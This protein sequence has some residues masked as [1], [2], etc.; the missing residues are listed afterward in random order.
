[1][2][3]TT[4]LLVALLLLGGT[5]VFAQT[6]DSTRLAARSSPSGGV[7]LTLEQALES[8]LN[9][10]PAL[11]AKRTEI[12]LQRAVKRTASDIGK[13]NVSLTLGQINSFVQDNNLSISQTIPFPTVL[14][15]QSALGDEQI[16]GAELLAAATRNDLIFAVKS[17]FYQIAV[18]QERERLLR[19]QDSIVSAFAKAAQNRYTAGETTQLE[20][21]IAALQSS[22]IAAS[23]AQTRADIRIARE[24]LQTLTASPVPVNIVPP[25]ALKRIF[26]MP[27]DTATFARNPLYAFARQHIAIA[28]ATQSVEASRVLPDVSVGYFSQTLVGVQE[29]SRVAGANDRFSGVPIPLWILPQLAKVE[30]AQIAGDIARLNAEASRLQLSGEYAKAVQQLLKFTTSVEF[31]ERNALP[32]AALVVVSAEASYKR[33]NI[34]SL[35]YSQSL[36]RVLSVKTNY[37]DALAAYNQAVLT[38]EFLAGNP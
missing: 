6:L 15:S 21:S 17:A 1:M 35:E 34:G 26:Q 7:S 38:L 33:G 4:T 37:V 28:T 3:G 25:V 5:S 9:R 2:D 13:T 23:L 27:T 14:T 8:A 10:N 20:A 32:Q 29:G 22:E 11:E 12:A 36:A 18:L 16:R 31:Y 24:Q 19:E 30:S